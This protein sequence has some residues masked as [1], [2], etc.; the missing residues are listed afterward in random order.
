M[1]LN[2]A[3]IVFNPSAVIAGPNDFLWKIEPPALA[4]ANG[5]F[6]AAINRVGYGK[7]PGTSASSS[8][9]ASSAIR[10]ARLLPKPRAI[11]TRS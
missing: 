9:R 7:R 2:G 3:E 1:G 11:K 8:A 10:V 6:V 5:F 4:V